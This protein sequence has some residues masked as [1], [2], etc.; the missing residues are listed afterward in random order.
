MESST[1]YRVI[2]CT[3]GRYSRPRGVSRS[4][5]TG[6]FTLLELMVTVS[7]LAILVVVAV[8][9]FFNL[10]QNNRATAHANDLVTALNV[11]RSEAIRRGRPVA[12][13][14]RAA[15]GAVSCGATSWAQGWAVV[16]DGTAGGT[17]TPVP[18]GAPI[19][20]WGPLTGTPTFA[21]GAP[22]WIRYLPRGG[23]ETSGAFT[24]ADETARIELR[25][26]L[27]RCSGEQ[28]RRVAVTRS[29]RPAATREACS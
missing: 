8:P 29:G 2:G 9:N 22:G 5:F 23:I 11:A 25:F 15:S 18:A 13:C 17:A 3:S 20:V 14:P 19:Q 10:V 21:A 4:S 24:G 16:A 26:Q 27:A 6:G 1:K 7:V 12:L 28:A